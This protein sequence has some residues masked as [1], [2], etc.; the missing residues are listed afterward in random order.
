[1]SSSVADKEALFPEA[2]NA[3]PAFTGRV[4]EKKKV[5][6]GIDMVGQFVGRDSDLEKVNELLKG[7]NQYITIHGFGG[8]G[9]TALALQ[10]AKGFDDGK[11]L[12]LPLVG[13]PRLGDVI[14]KIARFLYVDLEG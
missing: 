8:L 14:R 1:M 5:L 11:V 4:S 10:I 9:K 13:T 6:A 2:A 7:S 12:A 3:N